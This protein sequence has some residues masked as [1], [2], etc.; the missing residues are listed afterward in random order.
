M[1]STGWWRS[2][3]ELAGRH[4]ATVPD[5]RVLVLA[6]PKPL[7]ACNG[8]NICNCSRPLTTICR[9]ETIPMH[10]R[11]FLLGTA[12]AAVHA[13]RLLRAQPAATRVELGSVDGSIGGNQFTP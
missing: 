3:A 5:A 6:K 12:A 4:V 11:T 8:N 2:P 10:R 7:R 1:N 9:Q 13:S